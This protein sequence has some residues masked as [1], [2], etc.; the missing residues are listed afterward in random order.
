MVVITGSDLRQLV[1]M[2]DAIAAVGNYFSALSSGAIMQPQ[3]LSLEDGSLL[4]MTASWRSSG[5]AIVKVV[6]VRP[7]NRAQGL[8]TLHASVLW[9]DEHS[10]KPEAL[11]EGSSL[12]ALR[13]GAASGYAT[14]VMADPSARSLAMIGAGA[15]APDQIRAVCAVRPINTVSIF[16][17]TRES[18][19]RLTSNLRSEL[20][21]INFVVASTAREAVRDAAV[22]CCAT[23]SSE[24]VFQ[25]E[26]AS[27]DAH[28]NAVGAHRP[29]LCEIPEDLLARARSIA[30]DDRTAALAEAGD[31]IQAIESGSLTADRLIEIGTL[32]DTTTSPRPSGW[33]VF[34]SVGVAAQDLAIATLAV[35]RISNLPERQEVILQ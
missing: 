27:P 7:H 23:T 34:K 21:E 17:R 13:T 16:S 10:G 6:S 3:R 2:P 18:S 22:I 20:P 32:S 35:E 1:S 31:L 4:A 24:A 29:D 28:I 11:I 12:T 26:D 15:Q 25:S 33:T 9:I 8:P 14:K 19:Q 30:I 5:G